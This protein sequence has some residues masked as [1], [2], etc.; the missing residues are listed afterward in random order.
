MYSS[1]YVSNILLLYQIFCLPFQPRH[2]DQ[3][4]RHMQ[5]KNQMPKAEAFD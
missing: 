2:F 3:T 4:R 5:F 1:F